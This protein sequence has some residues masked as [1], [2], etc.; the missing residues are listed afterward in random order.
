MVV[1]AGFSGHGFKMSPAIG[2]SLAE[3]VTGAKK[4]TFDLNPLRFS[5]FEE[6][7]LL[8]SAYGGNVFA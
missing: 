2:L 1:G 6:D 7:D 5:R 3:L 4:T 8:K